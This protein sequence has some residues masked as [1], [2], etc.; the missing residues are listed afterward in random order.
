VSQLYGS[1]AAT[2]GPENIETVELYI[3]S[4]AKLKPYAAEAAKKLNVKFERRSYPHWKRKKSF[5]RS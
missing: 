4:P 5:I 1:V 2:V 3:Y